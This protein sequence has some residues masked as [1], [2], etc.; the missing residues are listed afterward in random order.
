MRPLVQPGLTN[1]TQL[2]TLII[3][4]SHPLSNRLPLLTELNQRLSNVTPLQA[5]QTPIVYAQ[6]L[7]S[8]DKGFKSLAPQEGSNLQNSQPNKS[9]IVQAK[10]SK[11]SSRVAEKNEVPQLATSGIQRKDALGNNLPKENSINSLS[12]SP[13]TIVSSS[14]SQ[15]AVNRLPVVQAKFAPSMESTSPSPTSLNSQIGTKPR[16]SSLPVLQAANNSHSW[17]EPQPLPLQKQQTGDSIFTTAIFNTATAATSKLPQ[18]FNPLHISSND[19]EAVTNER[20]LAPSLPVVTQMRMTGWTGLETP[21]ILPTSP[22]S[23]EVGIAANGSQRLASQQY[24]AGV[25]PEIPRATEGRNA[26]TVS[27]PAATVSQSAVPNVSA[28]AAFQESSSSPATTGNQTKIDMDVLADK[29]ERKLMRRLVVENER[30]GQ[31]RWR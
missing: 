14:L 31:K 19:S 1:T 8:L 23:L 11:N 2:A 29:I 5:E 26:G 15:L 17:L 20:H 28:I 21:L 27:R 9:L 4:R 3:S 13:N 12:Y 25:K 30:R 7:P 10:F 16:K 22:R 18:Q 6:P 24:S